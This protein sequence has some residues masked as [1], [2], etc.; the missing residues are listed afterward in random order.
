M[1]YE[2]YLGDLEGKKIDLVSNYLVCYNILF[3]G[4][5]FRMKI[6]IIYNL[7]FVIDR[8]LENSYSILFLLIIC[9]ECFNLKL[10]FNFW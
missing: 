10:F 8:K 4:L 9:F 6:F 2:F 1:G 3:S 7:G 5:I